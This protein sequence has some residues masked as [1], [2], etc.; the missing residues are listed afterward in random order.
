MKNKILILISLFFIICFSGCSI[1]TESNMEFLEGKVEK[2]LNKINNIEVSLSKN[3]SNV[4]SKKPETIVGSVYNLETDLG[5][6]NNLVLSNY[7]KQY[8]N[9]VNFVENKN[10]KDLYIETNIENYTCTFGYGM[11]YVIATSNINAKVYYKNELILNKKYN[12]YKKTYGLGITKVT[13]LDMFAEALHE[14]VL[15]VYKNEF[16]KDLITALKTKVEPK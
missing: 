11:V 9:N 15:N 2:N 16:Q 5:Q 7:F 13:G 6:I 4:L 10:T 3:N 1:K 8:F 12:G 14:S